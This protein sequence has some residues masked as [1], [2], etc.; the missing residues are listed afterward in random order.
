MRLKSRVQWTKLFT[1][2]GYTF[3]L[4]NSIVLFITFMKAYFSP[5]KAVLITINTF[6]EA[7]IEMVFVPITV[8]ITII[9]LYYLIGGMKNE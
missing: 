6:N 3:G 4:S 5:T 9:G 2:L 1:I 7:N 8:I